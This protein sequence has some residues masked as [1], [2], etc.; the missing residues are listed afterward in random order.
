MLCA[1]ARGAV[2]GDCVI[3]TRGGPE[4]VE[5]M[6]V[7]KKSLAR[8]RWRNSRTIKIDILFAI[9][10]AQADHVALIGYDVNEFELPVE[11]PDGR[12][13]LAKLLAYLYGKAQ[14][15]CVSELEADD[16]M[17]DPGRTPVVDR[18]I[19]AGDLR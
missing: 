8:L 17:R 9:V 18:E 2:G 19:D 4:G 14:R 15:R 11:T 7:F 6:D 5:G 12:I 13:G 10:C 3:P 1:D 16:G